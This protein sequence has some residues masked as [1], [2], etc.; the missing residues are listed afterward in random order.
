MSHI[1]DL[2]KQDALKLVNKNAA[3]K[4][5]GIPAIGELIH[6]ASTTLELVNDFTKSQRKEFA[7]SKTIP[8]HTKLAYSFGSLTDP[9][10][11]D[12]DNELKKMIGVVSKTIKS[13]PSPTWNQVKSKFS[14]SPFFKIRRNSYKHIS[15]TYRHNTGLTVDIDGSPDGEIVKEVKDWFNNTLL[16]GDN[17]IIHSTK[18]NINSFANIVA[19]TGVAV[20]GINL[21]YGSERRDKTILDIGVVRFPD[22][23]T[24]CVKVYRIKL[25]AWSDSTRVFFIEDN[26]NGID[27]E[28]DCIEFE[29]NSKAMERLT[30]RLGEAADNEAM[31]LFGS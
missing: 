4:Q 19:A 15:D 16:G 18:I 25:H 17:D 11:K 24:P 27:G 12:I 7:E 9:G 14:Q 1:D 10:L 23:D 26:T 3:S 6:D 28:F 29:A 5:L 31:N 20:T 22:R 13:M 30:G 2:F 21:I 8:I